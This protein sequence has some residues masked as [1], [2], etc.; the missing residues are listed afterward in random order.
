[1]PAQLVCKKYGCIEQCRGGSLRNNL[2]REMQTGYTAANRRCCLDEEVLECFHVL[3]LN[4][5]CASY[6]RADHCS[7][8]PLHAQAGMLVGILP[9]HAIPDRSEARGAVDGGTTTA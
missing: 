7:K 2:P 3:F 6:C 8:N 5:L 1:M 4:R 9:D